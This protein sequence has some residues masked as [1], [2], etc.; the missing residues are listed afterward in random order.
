VI[1]ILLLPTK[2]NNK[3]ELKLTKMT[4]G[5]NEDQNRF[6]VALSTEKHPITMYNICTKKELPKRLVITVAP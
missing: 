6:K 4:K 1:P 2:C 3:Y 5:K